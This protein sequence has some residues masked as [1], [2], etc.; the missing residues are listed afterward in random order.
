MHRPMSI[1]V[2]ASVLLTLVA[3]GGRQVPNEIFVAS[4]GVTI[5]GG[6]F[7]LRE[8]QPST[9]PFVLGSQKVED[10]MD[11]VASYGEFREKGAREVRVRVPGETQPLY[12]LLSLHELP[13]SA[14]G[15][16]TRSF[17]VKIPPS[18][19]NAASDG[20]IS[21]VFEPVEADDERFFG[22]ILWMS[23]RPF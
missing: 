2:T 7:V 4:S 8:G 11:I 9:L 16:G 15:P 20:R 12:G 22:W 3:C 13:G 18:Q 23:D 17:S 5:Q 1:A 21:V 10:D 14:R 19:V 6:G